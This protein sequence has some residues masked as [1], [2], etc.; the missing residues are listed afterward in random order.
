MYIL[1]IGPPGAGKGTQAERLAEKFNLAWVE[2]GSLLRRVKEE[3]TPLGNKVKGFVEKGILVPD[4][5]INEVLDNYLRRIEKLD[6]TV[7]DGFPRVVSQ[8]E[9][10]DKFLAGKGKKIDLVVYLTL[11]KGETF[12]R[13][14]SRRVCLR[15]G[16]VYNL[17]NQPPKND[18]VC[19]SC[20]GKLIIRSDETPEAITKRLTEF[21]R[22]TRPLIEFYQTKGILEKVDGDR[23]IEAITEDIFE[24]LKKRGLV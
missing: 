16:Q 24:R 23:S 3:D 4:K 17:L 1:I 12:K 18:S 21:E 2:M 20:G 22:Q 6:G 10:F 13:L 15:C 7:F 14:S 8:A 19:D 11:P 9:Y 5:L